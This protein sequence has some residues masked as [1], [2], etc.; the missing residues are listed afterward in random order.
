MPLIQR[1]RRAIGIRWYALKPSDSL[2]AMVAEQGAARN[3]D[4]LL[5]ALKERLAHQDGSLDHV[6][7]SAAKLNGALISSSRMR[8]AR[9]SRAHLRGAYFGYSDMSA[10]DFSLADLRET[11]F[12]EAN[13]KDAKFDG[14]NLRHANFARALLAGGSLR[15]ADLAK[16][17]FWRADLRGADLTN[18]S[19]VNCSMVDVLVNEA[20]RLP[21][22]QTGGGAL[23]WDRFTSPGEMSRD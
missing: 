1:I 12:R 3:A 13:L 19:M 10:A 17:N 20:T 22:G 15:A 23:C 11:N 18:A 4:M 9:F 21:D 16:A 2:I 14:A 6:D 7:W 5:E 8:H